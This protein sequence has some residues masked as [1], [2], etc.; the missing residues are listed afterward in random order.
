VIPGEVEATL[1]VRHADDAIRRASAAALV[2]AAIRIGERRGIAVEWEQR[3]DQAAVACDPCLTE[4]LAR[5][6]TGPVHRMPSGAG[7][8]AMIMASRVPVAML[9]LR[10]PG[11]I[12]HHPDEAVNAQDVEAALVTGLAFLRELESAHA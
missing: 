4:A 5:A 1:D 3:T 2:N 7:H 10:S 9:F 12:S 8:D 11:G 6:I